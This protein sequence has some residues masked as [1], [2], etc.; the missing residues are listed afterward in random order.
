M[1]ENRIVLNDVVVKDHKEGE[2]EV[3][4]II[5]YKEFTKSSKV[6]SP[7]EQHHRLRS[8]AHTTIQALNE[9][10]QSLN[11]GQNI[12]IKLIDFKTLVLANINQVVFLVVVEIDEKN[13][14]T[15]VS[16]SSM[17]RI[18]ALNIEEEAKLS[19]ARATLNA[20]NRK[21]SKYL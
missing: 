4:V 10:L 16:G 15:F 6:V 12:L 2:V 11:E 7:I 13:E 3:E 5:G 14:Q 17:S 18:E 1:S 21:M 19:V 9:L 20:T 8:V